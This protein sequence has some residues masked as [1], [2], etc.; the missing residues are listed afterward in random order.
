MSAT[1]LSSSVTVR[2]SPGS[3]LSANPGAFRL[4]DASA[5]L[6]KPPRPPAAMTSSVPT[7]TR[8]ASS[9]AGLGISHDRAIRNRQHEVGTVRAA[10]M[11]ARSGGTAAGLAVRLVVVVDERGDVLG[12]AQDHVAAMPA[13]A[14]V[15]AAE[16]LELLP[17]DR[18]DAMP[19]VA[20]GDV[21]RHLVD[22]AGNGHR[23]ILSGE[24]QNG[25]QL[26]AVVHGYEVRVSSPTGRC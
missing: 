21:Q 16:R 24:K 22:E 5:A 6:P 12:D 11:A 3:P 8:S 2:L 15:G 4:G 13:I 1:T 23:S 25:P 17:M 9:L 14:T 10:A 26:R 20:T 7:P 18:R 19:A